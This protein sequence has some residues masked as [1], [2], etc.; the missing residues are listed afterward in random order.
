MARALVMQPEIL[1]CDE[2][3]SALDVSIQAQVIG[4]LLDLQQEFGLTYLFISHDLAVVRHL[5]DHV[6]VMNS[7][8]IVEYGTR[9][10]IFF[11]PKHDY[12][13]TLLASSPKLVR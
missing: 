2:P 4:L 7:G 6:A 8:K 13:K 9:D 3:V 12:T 11:D 1:I 10:E 5:V